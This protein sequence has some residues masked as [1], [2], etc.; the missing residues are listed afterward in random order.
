MYVHARCTCMYWCT[1]TPVHTSL[2]LFL[3][4]NYLYYTSPSPLLRFIQC[5]WNSF[6]SCCHRLI[7]FCD[8]T[9][10]VHTCTSIHT[11][12]VQCTC[13]HACIH[14]YMYSTVYMYTCMYTCKNCTG[15]LL[16]MYTLMFIW[17]VCVWT[18]IAHVYSKLFPS[19]VCT[20]IFFITL[21]LSLTVSCYV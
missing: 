20:D 3:H 10:K 15:C 7:M 14:V 4:I 6:I 9:H 1:C 2:L 13:T 8:N 16:Y 21:L 12:T 18:I 5:S 17:C 11:C 19:C